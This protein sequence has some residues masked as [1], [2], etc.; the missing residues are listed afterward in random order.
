[1]K[2]LTFLTMMAMVAL[3]FASCNKI[4]YKSFVGT[5]G[6]EK[7]EYYNIDYAGNPIA[8]S[9]TTNIFDPNDMNN[10]IH[11]V[12]LDD[13]SGELR[14]SARDTIGID[15]DEQ[16]QSYDHFIVRP[17]TI[18]INKFTYSY[19]ESEQIL[20]MNMHYENL[21]RTFRL[22]INNFN[23]DSF[24]YENEYDIDCVEKAYLKRV[25]KTA[26]KSASRQDVNHPRKPGSL[27]GGR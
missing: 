15:W 3:L 13:K 18:I 17:D 20:Y 26:S 2:K 19:D 11:L 25:N 7:I 21:L 5:W 8:G 22:Q 1:M 24:I 9:L 23:K 6:V 12:F 4:D 14:D 10:G 27:L 16:T